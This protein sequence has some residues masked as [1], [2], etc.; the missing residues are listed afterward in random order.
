MNTVQDWLKHLEDHRILIVEVYNSFFGSCA[1]YTQNIQ[2]FMLS[3]D[4]A[5]DKVSWLTINVAKIVQDTTA[6]LQE[7]AK[8]KR[9]TDDAGLKRKETERFSPEDEYKRSTKTT[10]RGLSPAFNSGSGSS[11][12][13]S[14]MGLDELSKSLLQ[15]PLRG[16]SITIPK[17]ERFTSYDSPRPVF[18]IFQDGEIRFE[19]AFPN[20]PKIN[21]ILNCL[22][23]Q[24]TPEPAMLSR[25]DLAPDASRG[26]RKRKSRRKLLLEEQARRKA[27]FEKERLRRPPLELLTLYLSVALEDHVKSDAQA[28][29]FPVVALYARPPQTLPAGGAHGSAGG[30][31]LRGAN[32]ATAAP[33]HPVTGEFVRL[34][35]T[36]ERNCTPL[37][38]VFSTSFK[39]D[40]EVLGVTLNADLKKREEDE[41]TSVVDAQV[42]APSEDFVAHLAKAAALVKEAPKVKHSSEFLLCVYDFDSEV[43]VATQTAEQLEAAITGSVVVDLSHIYEA[44]GGEA[45][46]AHAEPPVAV[47]PLTA[48]SQEVG[49][50]PGTLMCNARLSKF[51]GSRHQTRLQI[52]CKSLPFIEALGR[53]DSIV[54]VSVQDANEITFVP[55][56]TTEVKRGTT[57]PVFAQG[58]PVEFYSDLPRLLK[59][60]VYDAEEFDPTYPSKALVG[61]ATAPLSSFVASLPTADAEAVVAAQAQA[62]Q[63]TQTPD[64]ATGA[65]DMSGFVPEVP[66]EQ[67]SLWSVPVGKRSD[68]L[69]LQLR[70]LKNELLGESVVLTVEAT[71]MPPRRPAY[72][73]KDPQDKICLR[74]RA[75]GLRRSDWQGLSL[76]VVAVYAKNVDTQQHDTLIAQSERLADSTDPTVALSFL[77]DVLV[78]APADEDDVKSSLRIAVYDVLPLH[79]RAPHDGNLLGEAVVDLYTVLRAGG[80]AGGAIDLALLDA[81]GSPIPRATV[82][83]RASAVGVV[84]LA[85]LGIEAVNLPV[86]EASGKC[87]PVVVCSV[88]DDNDQYTIGIGHTEPK[89]VPDHDPAFEGLIPVHVYSKRP[90]RLRLALYDVADAAQPDWL[91]RVDEADLLAEAFVTV[92]SNTQRQFT[93]PLSRHGEPLKDAHVRVTVFPVPPPV[94]AEPVTMSSSSSADGLNGGDGARGARGPLNAADASP[95][96]LAAAV[97]AS[98]AASQSLAFRLSCRHLPASTSS[99]VVVYRKDNATGMYA[100]AGQS[101]WVKQSA[102]PVYDEHSVAPLEYDPVIAPITYR[103]TVFDVEDS[104]SISERDI[105]ASVKV[106]LRDALEA[107]LTPAGPREFVLPLVGNDGAPVPSGAGADTHAELVLTLCSDVPQFPYRSF[108]AEAAVAAVAASAAASASSE[109]TAEVPPAGATETD[110]ADSAAAAAAAAEAAAAEAAAA[111]AAADPAHADISTIP[112]VRFA[113]SC[114]NLPLLE[115][116]RGTVNPMC[117]VYALAESSSAAADGEAAEK[118]AVFEHYAQT[119]IVP[120]NASPHFPAPVQAAIKLPRGT[121]TIYRFSLFDV[122]D[123]DAAAAANAAAAAAAAAAAVEGAAAE[124]PEAEA[125]AA[126]AAEAAAAAAA[127]LEVKTDRLL[128]WADIDVAAL[129]AQYASA[130]EIQVR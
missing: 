70:N 59:F 34:L 108:A 49:A 103:F 72:P 52:S 89:G 47:Y 67:Y 81:S 50:S 88:A 92:A 84:S 56:G 11:S 98:L 25:M 66:V 120:G 78:D 112:A 116:E 40:P 14:D 28:G 45:A 117:V 129:A 94:E 36:T 100:I 121:A 17:L 60:A 77:K 21:Y 71:H 87:E 4:D 37:N 31:A 115:P 80:G 127:A 20:P 64:P 75:S 57:D 105:L 3:V 93:A 54:C 46:A 16:D 61:W 113:I 8:K 65:V 55:L 12:S 2:S 96:D 119:A 99:L 7:E 43:D 130:T 29:S 123:E 101:D 27:A 114:A 86:S 10:Y 69:T 79:E 68:P 74:F 44:T 23:S 48:R 9:E 90:E 111:A 76:P 22:L 32:G 85:E 1:S 126:A 58:I 128:G 63:A 26:G 19:V 83:L 82:S 30:A 104:G 53:S 5:E 97:E 102:N 33:T 95:A 13:S 15:D 41:I 118:E 6:A 38:P 124:G 51:P 125:A 107:V 122:S 106:D 91:S 18:L 35:G 62:Y 24:T 39:L 42:G 110:S 109:A 73:P